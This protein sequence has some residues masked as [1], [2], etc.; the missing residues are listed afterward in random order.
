MSILPHQL[1]PADPRLAVQQ[2]CVVMCTMHGIPKS[3]AAAFVQFII[4]FL[5]RLKI[6]LLVLMACCR[7]EPNTIVIHIR[8]LDNTAQAQQE[9]VGVLGINLIHAAFYMGGDSAAIIGSLL[10]ELSRSR[11]EVGPMHSLV[12]CSVAEHF[13]LAC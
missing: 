13:L 8:M 4:Y 2:H 3:L 7:Q 5:K 12:H 10:N 11:I 1:L 9:A 6:E